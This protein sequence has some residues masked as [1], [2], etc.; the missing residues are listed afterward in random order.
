MS[1]RLS[2][3][4]SHKLRI[5][6]VAVGDLWAGAEVQLRI[7]LSE[8]ARKP[9]FALSAVLF[10]SGRL[11]DEISRLGIPV[12]VFPETQWSG[13]RLLCALD[14]YFKR[15]KFDIVHTHKYK[16]TILAAP[17]A[18]WHGVPHVVRTVHGLQEPFTG[19][20]ALKVAL[21]G[22]VE[23][24]V[25][26][27]CVKT[28][29]AVSSNIER[30]LTRTARHASVV[31]IRNGI[32]L[33]VRSPSV[34]QALKRAEFGI[35]KQTCVIGAVGRLTPVKGLVYLVKALKILLDQQADVKLLVAGDGVLKEELTALAKDLEIA[36]KV[37]ILGHRED[38]DQ[39]MQVMDIFALP[40]LSEGIPMALL[41]AMVM[42]RPVVASRVGGIPEIIE[43]GISG[44]LV[45]PG[46]P[47]GLALQCRKMMEDKEFAA[48]LGGAARDRVA[49]NFSAERMGEKVSQLY[50]QL[51]RNEVDH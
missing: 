36:E 1:Q 7:L 35:E 28:M 37:A 40:S 34:D 22:A 21:Y 19:M 14:R 8:L 12:E 41:E 42:S 3:G 51:C 20:Q 18:C 11:A 24:R 49:K 4:Y 16:D 27:C 43:D 23:R 38:T 44:L 2:N 9:E 30:Q 25:H 32:D 10:N 17:V 29:I 13:G 47:A 46:D 6:H 15:G 50:R 39:L 33:D 45:E 31:C 26:R 48:R 5:C